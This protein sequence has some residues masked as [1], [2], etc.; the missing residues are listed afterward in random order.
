MF[1]KPSNSK[2]LNLQCVIMVE[3]SSPQASYLLAQRRPSPERVPLRVKIVYMNS[4]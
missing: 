3:Q 2:L 4:L 1:V